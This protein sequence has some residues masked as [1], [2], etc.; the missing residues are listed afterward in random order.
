MT[1]WSVQ[2]PLP[3]RTKKLLTFNASSHHPTTIKENT[4]LQTCTRPLMMAHHVTKT[5][6]TQKNGSRA[7]NKQKE[8][9]TSS[10]P[11]DKP[12]CPNK[13]CITCKALKGNG[14][15]T[16]QNVI[17]HMNCE[18]EACIPKRIGHYDGETLRE[19]HDRYSEHYRQ[20]KNPTA[21]SYSDKPWAK[22]YSIHHPNCDDPK[23]GIEIVGHASSTNDRKI[24]EARIILKNNSD[25]N[26]KNELSEIRR[27]LV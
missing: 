10:R 17:Y 18:M 23:I 2:L 7:A 20:A 12:K 16:D 11:L 24:Q 5:G 26:D 25:L 9:I 3:F 21:K 8:T 6:N 1:F 19:T 4:L 14:N 22:H 13:N 15:C 27:F